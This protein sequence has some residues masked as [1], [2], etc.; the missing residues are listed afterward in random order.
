MQKNDF[1]KL[2]QGMNLGFSIED[3]LELFNYLDVQR[4]NSLTKS[5]FTDGISS[6]QGPGKAQGRRSTLRQ[7]VIGHLK[8]VCQTL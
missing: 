6:M 4:N 8:R 5:E 1:L 7:Q 3:L 2:L